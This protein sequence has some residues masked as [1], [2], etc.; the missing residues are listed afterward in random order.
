MKNL[1]LAILLTLASGVAFA[2]EITGQLIAND[3]SVEVACKAIY[4]ADT[5]CGKS[6]DY[7]LSAVLV[8]IDQTHLNDD[9]AVEAVAALIKK[10]DFARLEGKTVRAKFSPGQF[11]EILEN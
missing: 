4:M 7:V 11:A 3:V 6:S 2:D 1:S 9:G 5:R 10:N 8:S